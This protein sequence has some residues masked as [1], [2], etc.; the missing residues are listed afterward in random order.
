[1][2][3]W[4]AAEPSRL[5]Q[6][7]AAL[8][9]NVGYNANF[10][11]NFNANNG[12]TPN[13]SYSASTDS[14]TSAASSA[15]S[16]LNAYARGFTAHDVDA[17]EALSALALHHQQMQQM[18]QLH[19]RAQSP[20]RQRAHTVSHAGDLL[21]SST[22][23]SASAAYRLS[24]PAAL[25]ALYQTDNF[26]AYDS[27]YAYA[28]G[29]NASADPHAPH[30]PLLALNAARTGAP[31][32][33]RK[34]MRGAPLELPTP[35]SPQRRLVESPSGKPCPNCHASTSTLW[36]SCALL[37]GHHYLCN[38]CGL[39]FKKGKYCPLCTRVYYDA[40]THAGH[41]K[42]CAT[43]ANW[44]HKSCLVKAGELADEREGEA[45]PFE[46]AQPY[47]CTRCRDDDDRMRL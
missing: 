42:Q 27:A 6:T 21:P 34:S 5:S 8:G 11:A 4:N 24:A 38:A 14:Y 33:E 45:S 31:V 20:S 15:G 26:Y 10:N 36:R 9:S 40:D 17:A 3:H 46:R 13:G 16:D 43:C 2:T 29:Y 22:P 47:Q 25:P 39:R 44:T 1:M 12:W 37:S 41:F 32:E 35:P 30:T 19:Q 18:Q 28:F 7:F 23:S